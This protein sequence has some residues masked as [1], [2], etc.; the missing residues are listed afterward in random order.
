MDAIEK[1]RRVDA[2][3]Y[4]YHCIDVGH[5]IVTPGQ[6]GGT[7][8]MLD[9]IGLPADLTGKRVL[10][11]GAWDGFFTFAAEER[12]YPHAQSRQWVWS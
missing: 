11:I 7:P 8:W 5:G 3:D 4:W 9:R 2:V 1:Q 6:G 10:D 12:R